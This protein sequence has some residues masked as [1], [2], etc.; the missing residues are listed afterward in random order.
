MRP[1]SPIGNKWFDMMINPDDRNFFQSE[2]YLMIKGFFDFDK[3][4]LPI[5]RDAY[6]IIGLVARRHGVELER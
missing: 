4:I 2:G 5:Q 6:E 3:D 1:G